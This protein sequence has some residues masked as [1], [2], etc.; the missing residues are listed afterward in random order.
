MKSQ[1][2]ADARKIG[3]SRILLYTK[4]FFTVKKKTKKTVLICIYISFVL[5][6]TKWI[7]YKILN[8]SFQ[9]KI[10]Q[11]ANLSLDYYY[12]KNKICCSSRSLFILKNIGIY[13]F[14]YYIIYKYKYK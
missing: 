13:I 12:Q 6:K 2:D 11:E 5:T 14:I 8:K 9:Y 1:K 3:G 10:C 7:F 4:S